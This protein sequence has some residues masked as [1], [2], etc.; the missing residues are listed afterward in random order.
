M[1]RLISL[2]HVRERNN[3]FARWTDRK[4]IDRIT[5]TRDVL[6]MSITGFDTFVSERSK[7]HRVIDN[8]YELRV[9]LINPYG[10]GAVRRVQS[11]GDPAVLLEVYRREV[12]ASVD[13]LVS[14]ITAGK[15]IT[16]KFYEESPFWN[17]VVT[18]EYVWVQY[19]QDGQELK[20]QPEYVFAMSKDKPTLGLFSAFYMHFLNQWNDSRHPEYNFATKELIY[21]NSKGN[22][23]K[24]QPFPPREAR[25]ANSGLALLAM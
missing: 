23:V 24:S 2:V 19:C 14:L 20:S 6:V 12:A 1:N 22:E 11:L 13:R 25:S 10:P 3:W 18:G 17:L 8:S 4:L 15:K 16:L 9:M 5:G 7:L 21:R